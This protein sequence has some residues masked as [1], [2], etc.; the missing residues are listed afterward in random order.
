MGLSSS[1][2]APISSLNITT[3][4]IMSYNVEWGFL[5]LP[6]DITHDACGHNLPHTQK[7]QEEHLKLISKNIGLINPDICF[8]QEMG[9]EEAVKYVS[10]CIKTYFNINYSFF[11]SHIGTGQQGIGLLIRNNFTEFC[12][13]ER[14]PNFPLDR[15][16]GVVYA[17]N[18]KTYKFVGVHLKSLCDDKTEKDTQEQL[19]QLQAANKWCGE[20]ENSIICGD[21]NNSSS[22]SPIQKMT[23]YGYTDIYYKYCITNITGNNNTEFYKHGDKE[24]GSRIDYM[25]SKTLTPLSFHIINVD[26]EAQK[27]QSDSRGE[28][29]DHLPICGIFKL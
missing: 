5:T 7:A 11:Y 10:T 1:K 3:I 22:S 18:C 8:L 25:F 13:V 28:T 15:A 20:T 21:F 26:R 12:K 24:S 14:I 4:K 17:E 16:L 29:S 19:D 9:S 23:D 27:P 6:T 2:I